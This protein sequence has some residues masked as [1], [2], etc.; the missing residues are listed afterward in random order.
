MRPSAF[1]TFAFFMLSSLNQSMSALAWMVFLSPI[2]SI[3]AFSIGSPNVSQLPWVGATPATFSK[4]IVFSS[5]ASQ[6]KSFPCGMAI[7]PLGSTF[8]RSILVLSFVFNSFTIFFWMSLAS[9]S[10][11][12]C[13]IP[14]I[15]F[16]LLTLIS[17]LLYLSISNPA[18]PSVAERFS[19]ISWVISGDSPFVNAACGISIGA[20]PA[21]KPISSKSFCNFL[22]SLPLSSSLR[23]L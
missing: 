6:P 14:F 23:F 7:A 11:S 8:E 5:P 4:V 1:V 3:S 20:W 17:H 9:G 22:P 19:I 2:Q 10:Y 16:P 18:S 15:T 12:N 21:R 13:F